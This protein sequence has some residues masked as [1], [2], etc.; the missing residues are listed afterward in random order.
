[1]ATSSPKSYPMPTLLKASDVFTPLQIDVLRALGDAV[2]PALEGEEAANVLSQLPAAA[3]SRQRELAPRYASDGFASDPRL[4]DCAATQM[5]ASLSDSSFGDIALLLSLIGTRPGCLALTG[6]LGPYQSLSRQDR[7]AVLKKWSASPISLL[8]KAA[9]GLRGIV[10]LVFYRNHQPAWEAI[11]YPDGP[12]DDWQKNAP[13]Q[14]PAVPHYEYI[15]ENDKLAAQPE[16]TELIV[17]T[18]VLVIGTGSGGGVAGSYLAQRG[19]RT[20]IVDKG[21]YLRPDQV[22]GREDQGYS[23]LYEGQGI[24]PS[25]DA[26]INILAGSTF[27]GGTSINWSASL[28]PRHFV[29]RAWAEK[30]GV[31]YYNSPFFTSDLNAVCTRMGVAVAP[32]RHNVSNSLL[33]LGSQRAGQP[34]EPVPQNSGGHT[35]YCG[36]CQLGCISG[37]KQGG[38]VSWLKDAAEAGAAFMTNCRVERILFDG[39]KRA[40]GAMATVDGRRVKILASKGVVVSAGSI[41]TPALLLRTPELKY[42]KQIGKNLRLHPATVVTG[43]YN[44]PIKPWEGGLLTMVSNGAEMVDPEGWGCKIEVIAS[45]PSVHAAFSNYMGGAE[46]K[47]KMIRYSHSYTMVIICRDRDAGQV[48]LDKQGNARVKYVI[49]KFD[50]RSLLQGILRGAD[51]HMAAGAVEIST[52]QVGVPAFTGQVANTTSVPSAS[53]SASVV[54]PSDHVFK[55]TTQVPATYT[56]V[57]TVPRDLNDP[58]YKAWQ[59]KV[60]AV[61]AQPYLLSIGS[62]HQ[63]ASCRMGASP[64]SSALDPEGRVWGTK[65]LWV[66]DASIMPESSGVNPMI[67]TMAGARGVARNVAREIGAVESLP[68]RGEAG[69]HGEARL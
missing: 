23:L 17:D 34:V 7:E 69:G 54:P 55:E 61:G 5:K 63:M 44:F 20:L 36:K 25:E 43:Y 41:Q 40:I 56:P 58:A 45:S 1:M 38:V 28:K 16:G 53:A 24:M 19:V 67:T 12:A 37:H 9:S 52:A 27:G 11:G 49:S 62:A 8:R 6:Y 26:T 42:N 33:A 65:N 15:F 47:A 31:P 14:E 21:I 51:A 59:K 13:Q 2:V 60:I 4:L 64:S 18:E 48:V 46:H 68:L 39:K 35:H 32:I 3:T 10:L 66:A 30:Y 57:D 29:R 22:V 50:Q